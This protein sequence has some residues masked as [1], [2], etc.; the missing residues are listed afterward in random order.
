M[1]THKQEGCH[2][3]RDPPRR[4][5]GRS[6]TSGSP[7]S[8][9]CMGKTSPYNSWIRKPVRLLFR[10]AGG[11]WESGTLLLAY[12][13]IHS[14]FQHRGSSLKSAWVTGEGDSLMNFKAC[15]GGTGIW[16]NFLWEWKHWQTLF[17]SLST[18]LTLCAPPRCPS[19]NRRQPV[20]PKYFLP[21]PTQRAA[22]AGTST[23]PKQLPL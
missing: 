2:S 6:L 1:A 15:A 19:E 17:L 12:T 23:P 22:L 20:P 7:V 16:R 21:C 10:R 18:K 9:T 14:N 13:F 11:L 5:R 4:A 8:G 3:H